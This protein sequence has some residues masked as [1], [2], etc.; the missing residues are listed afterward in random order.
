VSRRD[1]SLQVSATIPSG[2]DR[3]VCPFKAITASSAC[4]IIASRVGLM[5]AHLVMAH[6]PEDRKGGSPLLHYGC[7]DRAFL[8]EATV[9]ML[10]A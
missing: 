2:A 8:P 6:A 7:P 4:A 9:R 10:A 5:A 1:I 3:S